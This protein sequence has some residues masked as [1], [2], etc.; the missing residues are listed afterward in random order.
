MKKFVT[1]VLLLSLMITVFPA[2]VGAAAAT[3]P[4]LYLNGKQLQTTAQAQL[5]GQSTLVP[6]RTVTEGLGF[7]VDWSPPNVNI[8]NGETSMVLTIGSSTAIVNDREIKL[9]SPAII[10]S[11]VTLVPLR[12]VSEQFGLDVFW[13]KQT[14]SVYLNE[15]AEK[16]P[17]VLPGTDNGG[18][19]NGNSGTEQGT[20][21]G[22][23]GNGTGGNTVPGGSADGT[24]ANG[25]APAEVKGTLKSIE[26]DGLGTVSLAYDGEIGHLVQETIAGEGTVK[27]KIAI[28]L[29]DTKFASDFTPGFISGSTGQI[30]T[31][32]H[33]SLVGIRYSLYNDKPST[34]RVVLDLT[35]PT[36]INIVREDKLIRIEV[37]QPTAPAAPAVPQGPVQGVYKVV[38]DA[39]HGGKDPGAQAVNGR[40]E[41][42]YNLAI[43]L[44]VKALL[45]KETKIKPY[46]TRSDDTF[47]ELNERAKIANDLKADL[48]ISFHAN[49]T[50]SSSVNGAETYYSRD[51]SRAFANV[52]QKHLVAGT[53]FAD[54]KVRQA[55]F[56]VI[57]K[58]TMPAVLMEAG[59][60]SNKSDTAALFDDA[61]QNR[62][63]AE[64]VAGIKEYLKIS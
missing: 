13:D 5:V 17:V 15:K 32:T 11:G 56:A 12:F 41:K 52:M 54:R 18:G 30:L 22:T 2:L 51:D 26:Y 38:L 47:V 42:E 59:Y 8:S 31:D 14:K 36:P 60:L 48:F 62:I 6:V 35:A 20:G 40:Y 9:E 1:A 49:R 45:D 19:T 27:Q 3:A 53:G 25:S 4:K 37:L 34:V 16:P 29:P 23:G 24:G 28:D 7:D 57:K 43:V 46:L 33:P 58:T 21:T 10:S 61:R 63:A 64:I 55:N 50:D 39:G 44:K